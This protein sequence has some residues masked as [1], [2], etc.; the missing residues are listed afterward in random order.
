MRVFLKDELMTSNL[1][2]APVCLM[3]WAYCCWEIFGGPCRHPKVFPR[4]GV[5][6]A[7]ARLLLLSAF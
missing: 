6:S 1:G 7:K 5:R 3:I 2:N 4:Q